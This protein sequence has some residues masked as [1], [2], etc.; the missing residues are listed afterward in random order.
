MRLC[1]IGRIAPQRVIVA[2][3]MRVMP[4]IVACRFIA[5]RLER[6]LDFYADPFAQRIERRLGDSGELPIKFLPIQC[7]RHYLPR[8]ICFLTI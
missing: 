3:A 7:L 5:P 8:F 6:I 2:D 4:D 1:G